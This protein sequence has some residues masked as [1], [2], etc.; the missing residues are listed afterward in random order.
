[1]VIRCDGTSYSETSLWKICKPHLYRN[2]EPI[3]GF[4]MAFRKFRVTVKWVAFNGKGII[5]LENILNEKKIVS[6][7][8]R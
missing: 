7:F 2:R 1:M 8:V 3:S 6:D 5:V 4:F